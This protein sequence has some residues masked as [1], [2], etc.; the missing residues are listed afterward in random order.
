MA[1]RSIFQDFFDVLTRVESA[2][3]LAIRLGAKTALFCQFR[4]R[5]YRQSPPLIFCQ[6]PMQNIHLLQGQHI[7]DCFDKI[8]GH[9]VPA[10]I[11]QQP[12][13]GQKRMVFDAHGG[14][15]EPRLTV[16]FANRRH[17]LP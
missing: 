16:L 15:G 3:R 9:E 12:A 14:Q 6:M 13:V 17:Q 4:I 11:Q 2:G 10:T 1:F 8:R 5:F 7:D